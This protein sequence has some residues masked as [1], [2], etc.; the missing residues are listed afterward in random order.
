MT[1]GDTVIF[2]SPIYEA[3]LLEQG[4][5]RI[6]RGTQDKV[7]RTVFIEAKDTVEAKVYDRLNTKNAAM[8][9]LL[10]M[11]ADRSKK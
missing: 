2:T 11:Q 6:V 3:D 9:D 10:S 5:A 4:I 8:Q 1:R 7:T